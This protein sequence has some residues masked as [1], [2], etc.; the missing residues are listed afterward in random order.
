[1]IKMLLI[2]VDGT[3]T[4]G[5][6]YYDNTGNELKKFNTRDGVGFLVASLVGI[7]TGI[8]TGRECTA[9]ARRMTELGSTFIFQN[10]K[11][12][13]SFLESFMNSKGLDKMEIGYIGDDINDLAAMRMTGYVACPAD[14]CEDIKEFADYISPIRG[15]YGAV[16]DVIEHILKEEGLWD[17]AVLKLF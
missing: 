1:M 5:G 2:D 13:K 6:I 3:L 9:T 14:A 7:Q 10:I 12:K 4:D 16:R 11:D 15:G 17:T 8:I